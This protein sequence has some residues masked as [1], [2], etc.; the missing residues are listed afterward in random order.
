MPHGQVQHAFTHPLRNSDG[1][2]AMTSHNTTDVT[3]LL[4]YV[5]WEPLPQQFNIVI[6]NESIRAHAFIY[7]SF[8]RLYLNIRNCWSNFRSDVITDVFIF[9]YK[10]VVIYIKNRGRILSY[11]VDERSTCSGGSTEK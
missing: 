4:S 3:L 10:S 1:M 8:L 5:T 11:Y 6:M 7:N 2:I 9:L